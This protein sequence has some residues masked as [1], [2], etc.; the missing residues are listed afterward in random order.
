VGLGCKRVLALG[1][2][3]GGRSLPKPALGAAFIR[4]HKGQISDQV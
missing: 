4:H 1:V 2:G 3:E